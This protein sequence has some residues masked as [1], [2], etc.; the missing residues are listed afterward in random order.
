MERSG[1]PRLEERFSLRILLATA[2]ALTSL[3]WFLLGRAESAAA[4]VL[5]QLLHGATFGLWWGCA[6][7]AMQRT[8]PARLRATGQAL[9]SAAVFGA[10]NAIGNALSGTG[11][12]RFGSVGPLYTTAIYATIMQLD[13]GTLPIY[14]R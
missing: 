9:F 2:F 7:E 4:L 8:V 3:R 13:K 5:L 12:D 10:G 14:Q 1:L 6:V 11:Y